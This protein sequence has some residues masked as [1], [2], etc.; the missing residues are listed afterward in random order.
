VKGQGIKKKESQGLVTW[1]S[2]LIKLTPLDL[3]Q[4]KIN[5][6][7]HPLTFAFLCWQPNILNLV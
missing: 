2:F 7:G 6:F 3:Y 5:G 4:A 1:L